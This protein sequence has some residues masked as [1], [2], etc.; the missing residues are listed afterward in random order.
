[1]P[2][3]EHISAITT[4]D[5]CNATWGFLLPLRNTPFSALHKKRPAAN[6]ADREKYLYFFIV[7]LTGSSSIY[8]NGEFYYV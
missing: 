1:M 5:V 7:R 2:K 8:G 4:I 3:K 6:A